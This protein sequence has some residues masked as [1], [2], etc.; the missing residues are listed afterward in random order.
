MPYLQ[1]ARRARLQDG[2][3]YGSLV[4]LILLLLVLVVIALK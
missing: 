4:A 3:I 1:A 2:I